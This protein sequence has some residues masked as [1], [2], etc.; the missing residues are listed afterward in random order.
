MEKKLNV[1]THRVHFLASKSGI[2]FPQIE[3]LLR[4]VLTFASDLPTPQNWQLI[5]RE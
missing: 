1:D 4:A 3:Y 5:S 2:A